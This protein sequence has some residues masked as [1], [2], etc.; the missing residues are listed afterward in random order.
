MSV[1]VISTLKSK[2]TPTTLKSLDRVVLEMATD[3]DRFAKILAPKD[4]GNL[5]NS[6]KITRNKSAS[7]TVSFGGNGIRYAKR[8]HYENKKN[9]QTLRY[10][11]RAGDSVSKGSIKKY[12]K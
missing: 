10:L 3:I 5:V 4:T 1:R 9:P 12:I 11:E 2:W 7:Y 8:R 6:G